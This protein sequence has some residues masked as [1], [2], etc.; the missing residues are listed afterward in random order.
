MVLASTAAGERPLRLW[1]D[2]G[3]VQALEL[4]WDDGMMASASVSASRFPMFD[5]EVAVCW[6]VG[7]DGMAAGVA[8]AAG[9][10][11]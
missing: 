1:S 10:A 7:D 2:W 5:K 4:G 9:G 3:D 6:F 11:A 8:A